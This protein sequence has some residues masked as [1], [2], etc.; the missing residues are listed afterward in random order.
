MPGPIRPARL[1]RT[2]GLLLLALAL[3]LLFGALAS[4][5]EGD[6]THGSE[7]FDANCAVCHG[8]EGQGRV[9][10]DLSQDFPAIDPEAFLVSV[11]ANGVSGSK[12]PAWS[13]EKG[14]PLSDQDIQDV[15]A[16]IESLSGGRSP[17]APT[18]TSLPVTPVP[19]V[20]GVSGDPTAGRALFVE[21]CA[22]CHGEQGQGL[23]GANLNKAFAS[24]N[25]QQFVRAT[26]SQGISGTAM[27]A[28]SQANGGPLTE[29]QIDD[30]SAYIVSLGQQQAQEAT[31]TPTPVEPAP[32]GT[33]TALLVILV[34][35]V[36][37]VLVI[38]VMQLSSR[39]Q[40]PAEE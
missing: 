29:A 6:V 36:V 20:P 39:G 14:G 38:V 37:A 7:I 40:K 12:M 5:Q 13:Q 1:A 4:A 2:G 16:F 21:N 31:P 18:A 35:V 24:I 3:V 28:W 25:P 32:S 30:I 23:V 19:T 26:V 34:L 10:A 9:G 17:M 27:P 8:P 33:S 11:I 15:A 22:M